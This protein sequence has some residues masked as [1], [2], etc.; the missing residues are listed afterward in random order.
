L[1]LVCWGL[2]AKHPRRVTYN[3]G[4]YHHDDDQETPD[5]GV[6]TYDFGTAGA[7][8]VGS[9]CNPRRQEELP[10]VAFYGEG[11][12]VLNRGGGYVVYGSAGKEVEKHDGPGGDVSHFENFVE[13]IRGQAE[14]NAPIA[15]GQ[16][17]ARLCHLGNIAYRTNGQLS[18]DTE[19]GR[20]LG[21]DDQLTLTGRDYREGWTPRVG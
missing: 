15:E 19:S 7:T 2:Q 17:A 13:A 14:L 11:G 21:G 8:W 1:D 12:T 3:G 18:V 10:F 6:A 9:S 5:T 20:V 4:R 16:K